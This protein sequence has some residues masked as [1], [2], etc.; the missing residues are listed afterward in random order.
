MHRILLRTD[1]PVFSCNICDFTTDRKHRYEMHMKKHLGI[2]DIT[3]HICGKTFVTRNSLA[4][5]MQRVHSGKTYG[6]Q[7]C[8]YTTGNIQ[9]YRE[10]VRVMHTHRDVKPYKCAYCD[11][12]CHTSGNCRKHCANRHKGLEIKWVRLCELYNSERVQ[13]EGTKDSNVPLATSSIRHQAVFRRVASENQSSD[14]EAVEVYTQALSMASMVNTNMQ[15]FT[16]NLQVSHNP[17]GC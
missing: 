4:N 7:F 17:L 11:F 5:H 16:E 12:R 3:C 2:R 1:Q 15:P 9:H 13:E 10:H 6:C 14:Q 8:D